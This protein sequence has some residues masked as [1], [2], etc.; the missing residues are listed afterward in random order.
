MS[1]IRQYFF[2]IVFLFQIIRVLVVRKIVVLT[3]ALT[4][5][6]ALSKYQKLI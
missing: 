1:F 2:P 3:L 4:S 5:Y 6:F